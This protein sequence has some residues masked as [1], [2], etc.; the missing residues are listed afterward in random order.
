MT[1][2]RENNRLLLE[3]W[4]FF[5]LHSGA[6]AGNVALCL[7]HLLRPVC[8][9]SYRHQASDL[10]VTKWLQISQSVIP[11]PQPNHPPTPTLHVFTF[12]S[13]V[14]RSCVCMYRM[15]PNAASVHALESCDSTISTCTVS[16]FSCH[17]KA[18]SPS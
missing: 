7:A 5:S 1:G 3:S 10:N 14:R 16:F 4:L 13:V 9:P 17:A 2:S 11:A 18:I 15:V 12:L 8:T 6:S